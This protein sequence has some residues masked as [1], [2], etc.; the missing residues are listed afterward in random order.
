M[1][2]HMTIRIKLNCMFIHYESFEDT[3]AGTPRRF[4]AC[5]RQ[6]IN[7]SNLNQKNQANMLKYFAE[8]T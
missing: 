1:T 6:V 8:D 7:F 2:R 5:A 3:T 4:I